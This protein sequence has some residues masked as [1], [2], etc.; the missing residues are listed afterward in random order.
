MAYNDA[1]LVR[2][3]VSVWYY[4]L[5]IMNVIFSVACCWNEHDNDDD[6][7]KNWRS[8]VLLIFCVLFFWSETKELFYSVMWSRIVFVTV[9]CRYWT[10]FLYA[11]LNVGQWIMIEI[12]EKLPWWVLNDIQKKAL[13]WIHNVDTGK[14]FEVSSK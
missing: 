6:E 10:F 8:L 2:G 11:C 14:T 13:W 1:V 3:I 5:F 4:L 9:S 7:Q 12:P